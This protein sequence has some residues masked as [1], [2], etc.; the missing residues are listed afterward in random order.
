MSLIDPNFLLRL[1]NEFY[2]NGW[3]VH[4]GSDRDIDLLVVDVTG[5]PTISWDE[6][7]GEFDFTHGINV[8]GGVT[9]SGRLLVDDTTEATSATTGSIQTD[10]GLGVVKKAHFGNRVTIENTVPQLRFIDTNADIDEGD[11]EFVALADGSFNLRTLTEAGSA[12]DIAFSVTRTGTAID[13]V[14][15]PKGI[16]LSDRLLA[17]PGTEGAPGIAFVGFPDD[18]MW[19]PADDEV[20]LSVGGSE[21]WRTTPVG[22]GI[23]VIPVYGKLEVGGISGFFCSSANVNTVGFGAQNANTLSGWINFNSYQDGPNA[24]RNLIVGDGKQNILAY[25]Q[26]STRNFGLGAVPTID[27]DSHAEI[28]FHNGGLQVKMTNKTGAVTVAGEVVRAH[29]SIDGAFSTPA[30]NS[31]DPIG[32]MLEDGV[33]DGSEAWIV[34]AGLAEVKLDATVGGASTGDRLITSATGGLVRAWNT[35]GAVT[36]HTQEIGHCVRTGLVNSKVRAMLHFN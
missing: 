36:L 22:F 2:A 26:G 5:T 35:G 10:G 25:F 13:N 17:D 21:I 7:P 30:G 31:D 16:T 34:V 18:G 20:A 15:F 33:A 12:G 27:L 1:V 11:W 8:T 23:E 29:T 6:A 9:L 28:G 32:I 24:F 14:L 4:P 3:H 19:H